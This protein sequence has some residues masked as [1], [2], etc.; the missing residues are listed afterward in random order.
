MNAWMYLDDTYTYD[1]YE[2][3]VKVDP[4]SRSKGQGPRLD[5]HLCKIIVSA[6]NHE[7]TDGS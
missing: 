5:M 4:R 3:D 2:L 1:W 7:R 6:I